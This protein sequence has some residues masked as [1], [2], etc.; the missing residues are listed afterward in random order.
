MFKIIVISAV[1]A[2][3]I[4]GTYAGNFSLRE[5]I[6]IGTCGDNCQA[7]FNPGLNTLTILAQGGQNAYIKDYTWSG[8]EGAEDIPPW[9]KNMEGK[10]MVIGT[11]QDIT[12][13]IIKDGIKSV[14]S[15][16]F[17]D[18][19]SITS[20]TL[21][22]SV[23]TIGEFAFSGCTGLSTI[24]YDSNEPKL[25][26]IGDKAFYRTGLSVVAIP[27]RVKTIGLSAFANIE[28]LY[29]V[30]LGVSSSDLSTLGGYAFKDCAKLYSVSYNGE[31]NVDT[32]NGKT[33]PFRN[34]GVTKIN[35][36]KSYTGKTFAGIDVKKTN[37][38]VCGTSAEERIQWVKA[39]VN[40][41]ITV[42]EK[43]AGLTTGIIGTALAVIDFVIILMKLVNDHNSN[44]KGKCCCET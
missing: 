9:G 8:P 12:E 21:G 6:N 43:T 38:L 4:V 14:G 5:D 23:K 1:F 29:C 30:T 34:T 26:T 7:L 24:E 28:E 39:V 19:T 13:V 37:D 2:A 10:G 3:F 16:A 32:G 17:K 40:D 11:P 41:I 36:P 31:K 35:V 27:D 25:E 15:R 22:R 42:A 33:N 20:V 44:C 18:M